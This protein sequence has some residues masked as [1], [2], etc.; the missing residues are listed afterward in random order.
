MLIKVSTMPGSSNGLFI[1]GKKSS[2]VI[3]LSEF[4][5]FTEIEA[6]ASEFQC[7]LSV[8]SARPTLALKLLTSLL[9]LSRN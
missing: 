4:S 2:L 7:R 8:D 3:F 1:S 6:D 9:R 5:S